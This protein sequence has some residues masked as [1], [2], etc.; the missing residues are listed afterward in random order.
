MQAAAGSLRSRP[1][2]TDRWL[3]DSKPDEFRGADRL[4][5]VM[6]SQELGQVPELD[7]SRV[8]VNTLF[9]TCFATVLL[10]A[11]ILHYFLIVVTTRFTTFY[12]L[13][14]LVCYFLRVGRGGSGGR[15]GRGG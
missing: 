1:D 10:H 8:L 5:L 15:V 4:I 14:L 3:L 12:H 9:T 11:A 6:V 13:L 7:A 2:A